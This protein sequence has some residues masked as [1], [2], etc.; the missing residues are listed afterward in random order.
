VSAIDGRRCLDIGRVHIGMMHNLRM[1]VRMSVRAAVFVHVLD[2][3]Y[4][5]FLVM[6]DAHGMVF[7]RQTRRRQCPLPKANEMPGARTQRI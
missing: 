1:S 7:V 4:P 5:R 3:T 2:G 6:H